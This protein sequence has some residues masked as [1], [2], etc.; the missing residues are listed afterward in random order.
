MAEQLSTRQKSFINMMREDEEYERR[1]FALLLQRPDFD[2]FFDALADAGLFDPSRNLG[3][4]EDE[5]PGY[6]RLPYWSVLP[7]LEAIAKRSGESG[8]AALAEKVLV[9]IRKVS[10]WR[11]ADGNVRDNEN[12]WYT[13]ATIYGLV[14]TSAVSLEDI[15]LIPTWFEGAFNRSRVGVAFA[16][17]ALRKFIESES[18]DDWLKACRILD[19]CTAIRWVD[20]KGLSND[21]AK[22]ATTVVEDFWLQKLI[23]STATAFG[24]K[25]GRE[26]ANIFL[27]RL[28]ELFARSFD[29]R[30][31]HLLRPA[32]EEHSQNRSWHGAPNRF[33]EGLRDVLLSWVDQDAAGAKTFVESLLHDDAEIVRRV[34]IY[35]LNARFDVLRSL[36]TLL[37]TPEIFDPG[38]LH[39]LYVLLKAR[40]PGF[41]QDEKAAALATI[42]SL[43][44]PD[45]GSDRS[46]LLRYMKRDWLSAIAGQGYEP[47]DKS[48]QEL[49]SDPTLGGLS[50]HPDFHGYMETRWGFGPTPHSV[51]ELVGFAEAGILVEKLNAFTPGNSWDGPTVKSLSDSLVDAIGHSPGVFLEL[52]PSFLK[53]KHEYQY[54]VIA[55]FKKL[56]DAWDGKQDD[57]DWNEAWPKLVEFFERTVGDD[58]FWSTPVGDD[59]SLSPNRNWIPPVISEFLRAGTRDDEKAYAPNLLPRTW[60]LTKILLKRSERQEK[61]SDND[62]MT[63]AINTSKG[64]AVE[65]LINHALRTCRLSDASTQSHV[66]IWQEMQPVFDEEIGG[67]RNDNFEFS[68]LAGAYVANLHYLSSDWLHHNFKKIFPTEF[69][70]N[71]MS[72]LDG[73]AYAPAQRPI[74]Q[75]L[76]D[77]QIIEWALNH[78]MKGTHARENLVQRICL[79]YLWDQEELET[80]RFAL[81]FDV[82]RIDD[83]DVACRYFW[84]IR[85]Q[86]L[87]EEQREKILLFWEKCV[88]WAKTIDPVPARILSSLSL[89]SCYLDETVGPRELS[90]LL[91]VAPHVSVD[92]NG[93]FFIE[94][95]DRMVEKSWLQVGEILVLLLQTYWTSFDY[96][97]RLKTLILKLAEHPETRPHAIRSAERLRSLPGMLQVYETLV[98]QSAEA[99]R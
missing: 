89:L 69:L 40:F 8:D 60:L 83:L 7:Y 86:D 27:A 51:Q 71:C 47:A 46:R 75:E 93:S 55:G 16:S 79:A 14:P 62:A 5:K 57:F 35:V 29:G 82:L 63:Q 81:L 45:Y 44:L 61:P 50:P 94:E 53:A 99:G 48:L 6:Y 64:K 28:R 22:E 41:S 90:L 24:R 80:P 20:Q 12:T 32:I 58:N 68:T 2:N 11:D 43:P 26:A 25:A 76:V 36:T 23:N 42:L 15:E 91:T 70:E 10:L 72:A 88:S 73:L 34:A 74:Y 17:G 18:P 59:D 96:E 30:M 65:A 31:T 85:D 33:V 37:F 52:L 92:Y 39:E 67:C 56:W 49:M 13:F 38:H 78:E 87:H 66:A 98:S 97:D 9:V 84:S 21:T 4:I 54:A 95:L 1:G 3:P 19:H 77:A